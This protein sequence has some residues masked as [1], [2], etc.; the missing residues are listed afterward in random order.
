MGRKLSYFCDACGKDFNNSN[1]LNIKQ[2]RLF[3]SY[4]NNNGWQQQEVKLGCNELHFCDIDC[5]TLV[6]GN[7]IRGAYEK[8]KIESNSVQE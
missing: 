1:H 5:M 3:V 2:G 6:L 7:K 8:L 4:I